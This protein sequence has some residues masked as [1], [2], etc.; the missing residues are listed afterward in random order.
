M[1]RSHNLQFLCPDGREVICIA[2]ACTGLSS[3]EKMVVMVG[4]ECLMVK[5]GQE[6]EQWA[7]AFFIAGP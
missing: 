7:A 1:Q 5:G 3:E 2:L 6:Q 4:E